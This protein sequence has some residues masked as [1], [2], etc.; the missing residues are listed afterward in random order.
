MSS[1]FNA[2]GGFERVQIKNVDKKKMKK[3]VKE[4][5]TKLMEKDEN[6]MKLEEGTIFGIKS[7]AQQFITE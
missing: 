7:P 5:G 2:T 3:F 6:L 1:A 4:Q